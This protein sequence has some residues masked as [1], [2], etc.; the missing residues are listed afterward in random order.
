[1]ASMVG[2]SA[3]PKT[4]LF[5]QIFLGRSAQVKR[6]GAF[7]GGNRP[8]VRGFEAGGFQEAQKSNRGKRILSQNNEFHSFLKKTGM[9][10]K[11]PLM[12]STRAFE[13][14][15]PGSDIWIGEL[16]NADFVR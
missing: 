8:A 6:G 5:D 2:E 14:G 13:S 1:M 10:P 4:N 12:K 9:S 3:G 11:K 16:S 15:R 7:P